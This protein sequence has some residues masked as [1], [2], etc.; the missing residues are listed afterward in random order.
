[1]KHF[2]LL[3]DVGSAPAKKRPFLSI[4]ANGHGHRSRGLAKDP[5]SAGAK[6]SVNQSGHRGFSADPVYINNM[7]EGFPILPRTTLFCSQQCQ[8]HRK[9]QYNHYRQ[10]PHPLS[11]RFSA[12]LAIY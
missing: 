1:M 7:R 4:R 9:Q 6:A 12:T 11:N 3:F 5:L 8:N 10:R 2:Q